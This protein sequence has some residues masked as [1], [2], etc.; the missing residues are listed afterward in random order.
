VSTESLSG[1][2]TEAV[3]AVL[4]D[5]QQPQ[6]IPLEIS[7]GREQWDGEACWVVH[8]RELS[9]T[10]RISFIVT[11]EERGAALLE[12]FA[13]YLQEQFFPETRG[14][15]G[16]ARPACPGHPHPATPSWDEQTDTAWW[17]C[18]STGRDIARIGH[19]RQDQHRT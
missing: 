1:W 14:G 11:P 15:W 10:G 5:L 8:L 18:P 9:E 19:Y 17:Q 12:R 16:Q 6:A 3:D 7:Y 4:A 2:L 13:D